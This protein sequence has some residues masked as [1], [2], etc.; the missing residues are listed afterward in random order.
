MIHHTA[1]LGTRLGKL[2]ALCL[3]SLMAASAG[4]ID[5]YNPSNNQLAVAQVSVG[6]SVY[7]NVV[8]SL[9]GVVSVGSMPAMGTMDSYNP[10][11]QQ[12]TIPAVIVGNLT[13][14]NVVVN[15]AG[16]VSVGQPV[17]AAGA[18]V[19]LTEIA[20]PVG[21]VVSGKKLVSNADDLNVISHAQALAMGESPIPDEHP[22][23]LRYSDG[24]VK[25]WIQGG[26][27]TSIFTTNDFTTLT[28]SP[29]PLKTSPVLGPSKPLGAAFDADYAG[30]ASIFTASNGSD[31]LLIYHAE[32]HYGVVEN[33]I[34]GITFYASIGLARSTDGGLT[35]VRS[36]PIITGREAMGEYPGK[37][38]GGVGAANPSALV[39]GGYIYVVFADEASKTGPYNGIGVTCIARAPIASDGAVGAWMKYYNGSFSQ[40]GL[41]GQCSKIVPTPKTS[42]GNNY[43]NNP[44]LSFNDALN[45]YLLVVQSD[46]GLYYSTSSDLMVWS[47]PIQFMKF[48]TTNLLALKTVGASYHYYPL[49]M[50]P[51]YPSEQLTGSSGYLFYAAGV[52]DAKQGQSV[53]SLWR[54]SWSIQ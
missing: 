16:V 36:G 39:T 6:S 22:T 14:H 44:D 15:V 32:N 45:A 1:P 43:T 41:G 47:N 51:S 28:P 38:M 5:V 54:R 25:L 30:G 42:T 50:S 26:G 31:L 11:T 27:G 53:H 17:A 40:P 4:A 21:P 33:A 10:Q 3:G 9:A 12:L 35:W 13:F 46:D 7:T 2:L 29:N 48:D 8:V 37:S 52:F 34:N 23:Y 18:R 19:L 20:P 49:L 24:S